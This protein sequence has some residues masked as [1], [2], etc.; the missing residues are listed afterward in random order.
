MYVHMYVYTY[1]YIYIYTHTHT[2]AYT[3]AAAFAALNWPGPGGRTAVLRWSRAGEGTRYD[4]IMYYIGYSMFITL[5]SI[6]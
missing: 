5:C 4:I 3:H 6:Q 1:I 2:Y